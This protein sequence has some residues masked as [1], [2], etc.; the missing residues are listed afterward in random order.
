VTIRR[1]ARVIAINADGHVLLFHAHDPHDTLPPCWITPGGG[2]EDGE[3]LAAAACR[4]LFE[5]TGHRAEPHELLGPVAVAE[6]DW[7]FRGE[8]I[9]SVD[10]YYCVRIDT[11]EPVFHN[12]FD[13]IEN[14]VLTGHRWFSPDEI[15]SCEIDI[16]PRTLA[17]LIRDLHSGT[18]FDEPRQL[19]W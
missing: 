4:E 12:N 15:D 3:E 17:T 11:F 19:P 18:A 13:E 8:P 9:Y 14:E 2:V 10:T 6:G 7:K 1:A 5:E 16:F